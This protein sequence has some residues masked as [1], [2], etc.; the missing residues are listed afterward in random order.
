MKHLPS[1]NSDILIETFAHAEHA[2]RIDADVAVLSRPREKLTMPTIEKLRNKLAAK[3]TELFQLNRPELDFGFYRIM[4]AKAQQVKLFIDNDILQTIEALLGK[5]DEGKMAKRTAAYQNAIQTAKEYG[6]A[7]PKEAKPVKRAEAS[8]NILKNR[9]SAEVDIYDHLYRFFERYYDNGDFISRRYYTRENTKMAAPFAIPY[10]GEEVMLHWAN[11]DQY[12]IKTDEYFSHFTF[13]LAQCKEV[14]DVEKSAAPIDV[15]E[16]LKAHFRIVDASEGEH[17]NGKAADDKKRF[18]ILHEEC[19]VSF[20]DG[21]ELIINFEYTSLPGGKNTVNANTETALR[22]KFGAGL[23]NGDI[24]N[25]AMTERIIEAFPTFENAETYVSALLTPAPTEKIPNRPLLAKYISQYT[26]RNTCDYFI[27]KDLGGFLKRELDF[28]IKNEV[29]NLDDIENADELAVETYLSKL[30]VIRIIASK[31]IDFLAQLENFQKKLWLKKKFVTE[32]N[33][34]ITLDRVSEEFYGEIAANSAQREEWVK[35]FAINE[36]TENTG[37]LPGMGA[38]PYSVP[39]TVDF[40]KANN[41]LALDTAFFSNSF[42]VRLIAS[43]KNFDD[44]RDGLLIHS[45]NFQALNLLRERYREQV[46]CIYIDPPYNTAASEILYKNEYKHSSWASLMSNRILLGKTLLSDDGCQITAIDD[47]EFV[48]LASIFD[49]Y[50][51]DYDRNTVIVNHHPAGAGLEGAN[52]SETHEYAIIS[53]PQHKKILY[54]QEKNE[55]ESSEIGFVR[56]GTASSNLR[57]GRPNSFY[58]VLVNP[59]S[60]DVVGAERPPQG[61]SYPEGQTERGFIRIYPKS[62]DGIE[63]VWRRSYE[64]FFNELENGNI[65]C[66]NGKSLVLY[67]TTGNEG[68]YRPIFSNW[69]DSKYNAGVYGTNLL[70]NIIGKNIFSYPKS[71]YTVKDCIS[72][73]TKKEPFST[74]LDYFAGSGTTGHAV[75]NLN[76]ED[77]GNRTYILVEMGDHFDTVLRPRMSKVMYSPKWQDGKPLTRND[78]IS[79][80]FKYIR[81][82]SYEDTLNNLIFDDNPARDKIMENN[83]SLKEDYMLHYLLDVETRGS[84]SLLNID[85][86]A[87]PTAYTLKVKKPGSNEQVTRNIDLIETFNYLLGLRLN[88][89]AAPQTLNA[90]FIREP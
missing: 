32:T 43:I 48:L 13:D 30:K 28:Y 47:T 61:N 29:M 81:L 78:G 85:S 17:G 25:L 33:Y 88:N 23:N 80:C 83:Q 36:I 1:I 34:S 12:Y 24:P 35:L 75:I 7:Y 63:R 38:P 50:F 65:T 77:G 26:A 87:D 84:Q 39:L 58:A 59:V 18:F 22:E 55:G 6:V 45:E 4:H 21:G 37:G 31:L 44:R 51:T 8:L 57:S 76:R 11:A 20:T 19:P 67:L 68:K 56:T 53:V 62:K 60:L 89:M 86:F 42:T 2:G 82:E 52:I 40:L 5:I 41:T 72:S 79:Q 69:T 15:G 9:V 27:H 49:S 90:S 54:G 73:A 14:M 16:S 46:K 10:N 74:I 64:S 71:I 3:L 70:K 66:K